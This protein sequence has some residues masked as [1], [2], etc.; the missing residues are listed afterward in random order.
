MRFNT[1][2]SK[3]TSTPVAEVAMPAF[4]FNALTLCLFSLG[5]TFGGSAQAET[6]SFNSNRT[7]DIG[8]QRREIDGLGVANNITGTIVGAGG[9]LVYNG[10]SNMAIGGNASNTTATLDMSGLS[11]FVFDNA[12]GTMVISGRRSGGAA[13]STDRSH[14]IVTFAGET[15]TITA[16]VLGVGSTGRAV[17]GPG[18]NTGVLNL[19]KQNTFN[20]DSLILGTSQGSGTLTFDAAIS[21]GTLK[22]RGANG[23]DAVSNIDIATGVNS[24]Y[25]GATGLFDTTSG[26]LDA[27]VDTLTIATARFGTQAAR[28]TFNMGAGLLEADNVVLGQSARTTGA[29]NTTA[30]LNI[31]HGGILKANTITMGDITSGPGTMAS[32]IAVQDG[33]ILRAGSI[34]AGNGNATRQITLADGT[35]AN[36]SADA[37]MQSNVAIALNGKGTFLTEGA[38]STMTLSNVMSGNGEML[39][40]G[41][42]VLTLTGNNTWSGGSQIE[43]GTLSF[44]S[45]ANLGTGAVNLN[46]GKL[47]WQSGNTADISN[48]LTV[49]SNGG[50]IDDNGNDLT[51][52]SGIIGDGGALVKQGSGTLTLTGDNNWDGATVINSGA[53]QIGNGGTSGS[54]LGDIVN[55]SQ[56]ILNRA[57]VLAL[58]NNVAGSGTLIQ[59]G[60][61]NSVITGNIAHAGG[62]QIEAGNLQVGDG[63]TQGNLAGNVQIASGAALLVNRVDAALLS[64][65]ISGQGRFEQ[66]GAG[67]TVLSADNSWSGGTTI[68]S[69]TLQIGNGGT[70]GSVVGDIL[71]EGTLQFDRSDDVTLSNMVTG[72]GDVVQLGSG[73]LTLNGDQVYTGATR[74]ENGTLQIN[75]SVQSDTAIAAAGTLTG[76]MKIVGSLTNS[77]TL[78]PGTIGATN[79]RSVTVVGDYIGNDGVLA[80]N[81]WLG[82]DDSPS[83]QLILDGGHASGTTRVAITNTN[84]GE[85]YTYAD[86]IKVIDAINGAT[87]DE[88]AFRLAG[89]TR[90]GALSY[91][92]FRG[93]LSGSETDSWYLRNQF[94][95]GPVDPE[96]TD[97][98]EPEPIDPVAPID[99]A[100]PV[101]PVEPI[102]PITPIDP[103]EP[104][105]GGD[106]IEPTNPTRPG[107][108]LPLT[109]PPAVLPPGEYPVIGPAVATYG[110]VQP[111]AREL[112]MLTLGTRDQRSGDAAMM[113][114]TGTAEGPAMWTRLLASEIDHAYQAFAAPTAKGTL[115]GLQIGADVW[116]GS[117]IEGHSERFGLYVAQTRAN[118]SVSG[119]VTNEAGTQ[120]ERQ[121][122]GKV[123]L[124]GTSLGGY[125]THVGPGNSYLD[126]TLQGTRYRGTATSESGSLD[127][128]GYGVV[129]SLETGYPFALPAFGPG[130]TLEPQAQLIWQ[131][132][133]FK[134]SADRQSSVALGKTT[135]TTGRIGLRAKWS[136]ETASGAMVE[137][138]ASVNYWQDWNGRAT[139]VY[140]G[141]DRA[142][143]A[144]SVGRISTEVGVSTGL[145][146]NLKVHSALGYQTSASSSNLEKRES[147][148]VGL[149]LCYSF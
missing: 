45:S 86:G 101:D 40:S 64:G 105:E 149:G 92:L 28:G 77:G 75:G 112:G 33:A 114:N 52:S 85:A 55:N 106:L 117:I 100:E 145:T 119:L 26:T 80:L 53:V 135:G 62:T 83:D 140:D 54:V 126:A 50:I 61:G 147:Y 84:S 44:A 115:G 20:V 148:S 141:K 34:L 103:D 88:D 11:N 143:L 13:N 146:T 43:Q 130:F 1:S 38:G 69:G 122:T 91:R 5:A 8:D 17:Q 107:T 129:A 51:F 133:R 58:T 2:S 139:T 41:E 71:N 67:T 121:N 47:L 16:S 56:L 128:T 102:I 131:E 3:T 123:K 116:Q 12:S 90:S 98:V 10:S 14:G 60:S 7:E 18:I 57:D 46:G 93:S 29:G 68:S 36:L 81:S 72:S 82:A 97:P 89:D 59:R 110:V 138:F 37:D 35:L 27:K 66:M 87:T 4:S 78:R 109:P 48:R 94:I 76:E 136:I 25:S 118:I 104:G 19:G 15:N 70:S 22:L 113:A 99:P 32:R 6:W 144:S 73:K 39:K 134:D 108:E 125:W 96:P 42:G 65:V 63:G 31:S 124:T 74:V 95:V 24:N 21:D 120:Y 111:I 137:P 30:E 127:V 79:Y 132:T 49:G 142:P 23:V 9:T